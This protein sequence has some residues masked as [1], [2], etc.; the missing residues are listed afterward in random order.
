LE[1]TSEQV[2][3]EQLLQQ[4]AVQPLLASSDEHDHEMGEAILSGLTGKTLLRFLT[5]YLFPYLREMS[6]S[7]EKGVIRQI[8][9]EAPS[10]MLKDGYILRDAIAVIDTIDFHAPENVHTLSHLYESLLVRMG[11]EGGMSANSIP[12]DQSFNLWW[13]WSIQRLGRPF[14]IRL[15]VRPASW[16]KPMHI[17]WKIRFL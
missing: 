13:R 12:R 2:K 14:M 8:F 17:C 15:V 7:E 6:G 9:E 5:D 1:N 3:T 10:K 11:R 4:Q 16:W